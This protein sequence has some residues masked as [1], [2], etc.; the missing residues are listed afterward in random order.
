MSVIIMK[1]LW[2]GLLLII[3]IYR[4]IWVLPKEKIKVLAILKLNNKNNY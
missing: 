2:I 1:I 4:I 3:K